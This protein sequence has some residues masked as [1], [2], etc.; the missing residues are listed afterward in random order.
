MNCHFSERVAESPIGFGRELL[1]ADANGFDNEEASRSSARKGPGRADT[2]R[3]LRRSKSTVIQPDA[4]SVMIL[5][6]ASST[7]F[8]TPSSCGESNIAR[9]MVGLRDANIV[10][11][12]SS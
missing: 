6:I 12:P 2:R 1:S 10:L 3:Q 9:R 11:P 7:S 5:T 4:V 8:A